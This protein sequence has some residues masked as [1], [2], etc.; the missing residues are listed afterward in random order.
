[1]KVECAPGGGHV[2]DLKMPECMPREDTAQQ[3][4][5]KWKTGADV[6]VSKG[7]NKTTEIELLKG[8]PYQEE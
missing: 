2:S 7:E 6:P 8:A 4:G 3:R 1:V 5:E